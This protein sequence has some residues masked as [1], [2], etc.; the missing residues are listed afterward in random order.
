MSLKN[1]LNDKNRQLEYSVNKLSIDLKEFDV[2]TEK[3]M[4]QFKNEMSDN[5][6][7]VTTDIKYLE[8]RVDTKNSYTENQIDPN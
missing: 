4:S 3:M 8:S 6:T 2:N 7:K 5:L 1:E